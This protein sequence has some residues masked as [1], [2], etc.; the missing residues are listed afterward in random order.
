MVLSFGVIAFAA[1]AGFVAGILVGRKNAGTVE[2]V[3]AAGKTV[4]ADAKDAADKIKS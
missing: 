4:A 1:V 2:K 3:V